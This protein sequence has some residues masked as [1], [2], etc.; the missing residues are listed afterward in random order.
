MSHDAMTMQ[1]MSMAFFTS[2]MTSLYSLTWTPTSTG[3]YAGTCIFLILL[4]VAFRGLMAVKA[5]CEQRW[6]AAA[7]DRRFVV[8]KGQQPRAEQIEG[9]DDAKFGSFVGPNGIEERV[10]YVQANGGRVLPFRLTVDLPRAGLVTLI[11]G[12]GY[13]L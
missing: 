6:A 3:A 1:D 4:G 5:V 8:V 13:L 10:K 2:T 9:D 7:R 11:A 12:V